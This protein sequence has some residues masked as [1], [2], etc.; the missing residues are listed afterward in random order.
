[1]RLKLTRAGAS[2]FGAGARAAGCALAAALAVWPAYAELPPQPQALAGDMPMANEPIRPVPQPAAQD[3]RLVALG[4][5]LFA[6]NRLSAN[7]ATSCLSCHDVAVNGATSQ[8]FDPLPVEGSASVNTPTVFNAALNFRLGWFG[9]ARTLQQ[10]AMRSM[11]EV[12]QQDAA[13]GA[14]KLAADPGMVAAFQAVSGRMPDAETILDALA[15]YQNT[16]LTPQSAFDLWLQGAADAIS[17]EALDGYQIFKSLGCVSCHQGVNVGGNLFQQSGVYN[18]LS[19]PAR[20]MVRVPSLRNVATTAPYF[21]DGSAATLSEAVG[22]MARAQL[23][24]DVPDAD[25]HRIVA[26]LESLTGRYG[27]HPVTTQDSSH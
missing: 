11:R 17:Q 22:K 15:A 24:R 7:G 3:T 20:P 1:M 8:R 13:V 14:E 27:G 10:Q 6:D 21:H 16:L 26:F 4:Q 25:V 19:D 9:N 5:A 12:M 18:V 23:D 2:V